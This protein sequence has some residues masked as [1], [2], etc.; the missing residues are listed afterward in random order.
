MDFEKISDLR[1]GE[2][3]HQRAA[4]YRWGGRRA[5]GLAAARQLQGK[6]LSYNNIVDVEAALELVREFEEPACCVIKHTNP[7]G[8]ASGTTLKEAYVKAYEADSVSAFGSVIGFNRKLDAATANELSKLFVEA[9]VAP[10][11]DAD[12]LSILSGRKNLRLLVVETLDSS[13]DTA[14]SG[15]QVRRV[16]GGILLQD[17]DT[18]LIGPDSRIVTARQPSDS[19]YK[20]LAFAFRVVKHVK[21]NAIVLA[22]GGQTFG[23][24]AGQMSRVDAVRISIQ[25]AGE[26]SKGAVLASD[27]FFPFRDGIDE[28]GRAG[29]TAII[30]PGGSVRD[31]EAIEAANEHGISMI[32]AGLRHF[33]H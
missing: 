25:K 13:A 27:A 3:P 7:C 29:I 15:Y 2:N 10:G 31:A 23:V 9:V 11:F 12:A 19:E 1:Y 18:G 26:A 22:R 24:G 17:V 4:F 6:E 20:D 28:A 14:G 5:F 33:K 8:T 32:F 21:S 16:S 30:Q